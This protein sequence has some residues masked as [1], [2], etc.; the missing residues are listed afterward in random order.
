[1]NDCWTLPMYANA[2]NKQNTVTVGH[3]NKNIRLNVGAD[4]YQ[5]NGLDNQVLNKKDVS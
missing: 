5:R 3:S 2:T 1:M 4:V